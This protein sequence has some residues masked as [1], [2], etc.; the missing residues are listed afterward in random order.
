MRVLGALA[1]LTAGSALL[2]AAMS[3]FAPAH[4]TLP[5]VSSEMYFS[6]TM[7]SGQNNAAVNGV[8]GFL[9]GLYGDGDYKCY[10]TGTIPSYPEGEISAENITLTFTS[11][12]ATSGTC[13]DYAKFGSMLIGLNWPQSNGLQP[14]TEDWVLG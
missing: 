10:V 2:I 8:V 6:L 7:A 5:T 9:P 13:P 14:Q 1:R 11:K 4:A 3:A 12:N